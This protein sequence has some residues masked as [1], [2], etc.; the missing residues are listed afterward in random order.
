[1]VH[2]ESAPFGIEAALQ[3]EAP[4]TPA[5]SDAWE[6]RQAFQSG[7]Q[8][9][10]IQLAVKRA[11]DLL[12]ALAALVVL[13]VPMALIALAIK[14]DS[15]GPIFFVHER[16]GKHGR[17]FRMYK[18][19]SMVVDAQK[20]K[21]ELLSMNEADGPLFKIRHEPRCTRVGQFLRRFCL[22]ELPQVF[23]VLQN[24]MS[25]VG[26]R[27]FISEEVET[28]TAWQRVRCLVLPGMTGLWQ[29]SGRSELSFEQLVELDLRYV[30]EWS[31]KLDLCILLRTIPALVSGKGAY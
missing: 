19:R 8:S 28:F 17:R 6:R 31:L 25:L 23:N 27:P 7:Q 15:P 3:I 5:E 20:L 22:D 1:M 29:V 2:E 13:I 4:G 12:I 21:R 10:R 14:V 26:P 18:F 11:L 16:I 9:K 30:T 24:D